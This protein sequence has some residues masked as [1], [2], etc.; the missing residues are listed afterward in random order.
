MDPLAWKAELSQ[1]AS[2]WGQ[3]SKLERD[4]YHAKAAQENGLRAEAMLQ[5][6][7]STAACSSHETPLGSAGFDAAQQLSKTG[8]RKVVRQRL[9][10][11]YRGF[12]NH[13]C[14]K[15]WNGGIADS[16][17]CLKLDLVQLKDG[18][19]HVSETWAKVTQEAATRQ[20]WSDEAVKSIHHE[21]CH[22]T[23]GFCRNSLFVKSAA[24]FVGV[25]NLLLASGPLE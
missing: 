16:E 18:D 12:R 3:L 24:D 8:R 21:T 10:N 14:W 4:P 2:A 20:D 17:S 7:P 9:E 5:P 13:D 23:H 1:C 6:L 22:L 19:S 11:T 25:F 15:M